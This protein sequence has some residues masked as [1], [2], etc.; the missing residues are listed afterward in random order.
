MKLLVRGKSKIFGLPYFKL[1][2]IDPKEKNADK[3]ATV[4]NA[5]LLS[6]RKYIMFRSQITGHKNALK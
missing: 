4:F 2:K 1:C 5:S 3:F 6:S